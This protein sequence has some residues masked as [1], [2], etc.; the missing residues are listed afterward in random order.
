MGGAYEKGIDHH[1]HAGRVQYVAHYEFLAV[2]QVRRLLYVEN[3]N[4]V[5][6]GLR[7][8]RDVAPQ[9]PRS[10]EYDYLHGMLLSCGQEQTPPRNAFIPYP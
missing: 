4:L 1:L 6:R 5:A 3:R 8:V 9:E 2:R 7:G 10:S